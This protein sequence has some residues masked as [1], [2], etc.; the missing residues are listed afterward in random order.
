MPKL[1]RDHCD[2]IARLGPA[3]NTIVPQGLRTERYEFIEPE[4]VRV[5]SELDAEYL[6]ACCTSN[7]YICIY[8]R[9]YITH[10]RN[11]YVNI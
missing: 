5:L 6:H 7:T 9:M 4:N 11:M 8:T 1:Y 10:V 2:S 3:S